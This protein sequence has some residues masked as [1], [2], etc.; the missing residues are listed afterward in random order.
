MSLESVRK[1]VLER[2]KQEAEA[3]VKEAE[4]KAASDLAEA[5]RRISRDLEAALERKRSELKED[6][7]RRLAE[8][9]R[10]Q[11][12]EILTEKNRLIDTIFD[13]LKEKLLSLEG[14]AYWRF[15]EKCLQEIPDGLSG[16]VHFPPRDRARLPEGLLDRINSRRRSGKLTLGEPAEGIEGGFIFRS[17]RFEMN[18]SLGHRLGELRHDEL[19][20]LSKELFTEAAE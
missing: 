18:A 17:E 3:I 5:K 9:R 1:K 19:M 15:V 6:L 12:M 16:S 8:I 14:E 10:R 11:R 4:T 2:A 20:R 7:N 13:E